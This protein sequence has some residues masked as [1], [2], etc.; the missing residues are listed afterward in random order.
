M[1]QPSTPSSSKAFPSPFN[2]FPSLSSA[3]L[4]LAG[5]C[6][7]PRGPPT[8]PFDHDDDFSYALHLQNEF[9]AEDRVLTAQRTELAKSTQRLFKCGICMEDMPEDSIARPDPCGHPFC[10]DCLRGHVSARLEEHRLPILCPTCTTSTGKGGRVTGEVS[11]PIALDLGLTDQQYSIWTEVEMTA[12]SVLLS[13]RKCQQS[14]FVARDEHEEAKII[15]CPLPGCNHLWCKQCQQ[16]IETKGS[17]HSC[18]GTSELDH[19]MKQQGWKR[20]PTCKT[21]IQKTTGC[22]HMSCIAPACNTHFCY[23]CGNL[24]VRSALG[25]EITNATWRHFNRDCEPFEVPAELQPP[26]RSMFSI[27]T[28]TIMMGRRLFTLFRISGNVKRLRM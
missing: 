2:S 10:R 3:I 25:Q 20:C 1:S 28:A 17:K 15:V 4:R 21:P 9:D 27:R 14:M 22:N 11:Q 7:P 13:C 5:F 16:T 26:R 12:F 24:I 6:D 8:P 19:L 18:D 23:L